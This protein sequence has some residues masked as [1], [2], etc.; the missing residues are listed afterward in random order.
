VVAGLLLD[1]ALPAVFIAMLVG[2]C[3]AM[4]ALAMIVER[5]ITPAVNGIEEPVPVT[6]D[7]VT[8]ETSI[9]D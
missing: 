5:A 7:P 2:C 9:P 8:A 3:A 4:A 1:R 6:A